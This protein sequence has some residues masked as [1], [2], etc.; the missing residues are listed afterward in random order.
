VLL[1]RLLPFLLIGLAAAAAIV[2]VG[3]YLNRGSHIRLEGSVQKVRTLAVDENNSIAFIDFRFVN[4]SN[5]R[6]LVNR[7]KVILIDKDGRE[8]E[9]TSI[10]EVDA[11]RLFEYYPT[12]GQKYNSTLVIRENIPAGQSM[13]RMISAQFP[14]PESVLQE[15]KGL[16]ILIEEVDRAVAE[17]RQ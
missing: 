3:L 6:F 5:F 16:R 9:G 2:G 10:A 15:R 12:L 17:I 13:D 11:R 8:I 7:V 14:V 4:P 1:R